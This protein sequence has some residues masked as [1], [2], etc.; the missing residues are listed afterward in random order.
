MS[1][2]KGE[3]QPQQSQISQ[4]QPPPPPSQ[5]LQVSPSTKES[6]QEELIVK[7][8]DKSINLHRHQQQPSHQF[9]SS[10]I[11]PTTTELP[12]Q[13]QQPL[14]ALVS[15]KRPRF[16][17]NLTT[18]TS[19]TG[20]WK[21]VSSQ[22]PT[23]DHHHHHQQQVLPSPKAHNLTVIPATASSSDTASSPSHSPIL[24][25]PTS[26]DTA[27][28]TKQEAHHHQFRKGKYVSPVW[29]PHEMLWLARAWRLQYHAAGAGAGDAA[30]TGGRGKTRAE[31]DREVA[32]FLRSHGVNRDAKTAGT[33]WDNMLGEFRKVYEWER[34]GEREQVGK[35][36]FRLSP[37]E[38]KIHRLPASF[39]EEVFEEL[40]QFMGSRI[41]S[42]TPSVSSPSIMSH[43]HGRGGLFRSSPALTFLGSFGAGDEQH[44]NSVVRS[45]SNYM[46]KPLTPSAP[47][48][49]LREDDA[50]FSVRS[51]QLIMASG[52]EQPYNLQGGRAS[53][54]GFDQSP[55]L[56][57]MAPSS[58]SSSRE[59]RRVGRI[60]MTWEES[61]SLWA[62]EDGDHH[63]GRVKLQGTNFLNADDLTYFDDSMVACSLESFTDGPLKGFSVDKFVAGQQLKV[64]GRRK[65][66]STSGLLTTRGAI[67]RLQ[68]PPP[69]TPT[70][71][72]PTWEISDPTDYYMGCLRVPPLA[73]PSLY[74]LSWHIQE[75]PAEDLRFPIR[76]DLYRDLPQGKELFITTSIESSLDSRSF[77][78][79]L[80]SPL[81]R[82]NP[83]L[84]IPSTR[85]SFI[86]LWEDCIN[87]LVSR[88]CPL[89]IN[90]LR[91]PAT[92]RDWPNVTGFVKGMCLW[93]GEEIDRLREGESA[94]DSIVDKLYWSYGD[95]PY[96]LGYYAVGHVVTFCALSRHV[97]DSKIVRTDLYSLDL[98]VPSERMKA[99]VPC[100][101]IAC[102]LP[103]L[104]ERPARFS[105][106]AR[107]E[108]GPCHVAAEMTPVSVTRF[109]PGKEKWS[110]AKEVYDVLERRVPYT[111]Q[112]TAADET[113][114]SITFCPRGFRA[115]PA[116]AEELVEALKHVTKAL[117]A[118]H[119]LCFMHRD[120]SWEKV[121]RRCD[122]DG[123]W[124]VCG[125]EEM[126][127]APQINNPLGPGGSRAPEMGRSSGV[128]GVK[129]DVWGVGY[130]VRT[131]GIGGGMLPKQLKELE[132]RCLDQNPEQRPT[133]ADCYHH[134]LQFQA[135]VGD[136]Y[137]D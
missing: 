68:L 39:D 93:R 127:T 108:N 20:H 15:V 30:T 123:E 125:F 32:E 111:E 99:L 42:S 41:R 91:K 105:D 102:L 3:R 73:L 75:P 69:E 94:S 121:L 8:A 117:V 29:K 66:A 101:R 83:V 58:S 97:D 132:R 122:K 65:P 119:D 23:P 10:P 136:S 22:I 109:Y 87:R 118:L 56:E 115:K 95:L 113:E 120:L 25:L 36:Y 71:S 89:Q 13:Q 104:A 134:L 60:R 85:D 6:K 129:V 135:T 50:S 21:L 126:V 131:S 4:Q 133:A 14:D 27:T 72:T 88:F 116:T 40:S 128:H 38:R 54:L 19:T 90:L 80:L 53:L 137:G 59:L 33:K 28:T 100:W 34:G 84:S 76:K 55:P 1:E 49:P 62:D 51:R 47:L 45:S 5:L 46:M 67:E 82:P 17:P 96:V 74:E 52:M 114:L 35:S 64:L 31:K 103:L 81:I 2:N 7:I 70:R 107:V 98:S 112:V 24:S 18:A 57:I 124:V 26:S 11:S 86:S 61:V 78:I 63:K 79:D 110:A 9:I 130:L 48:P 92:S 43:S 106:F 44:N 77:T 16:S 37:Y 12:P